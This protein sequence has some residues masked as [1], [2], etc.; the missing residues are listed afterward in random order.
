MSYPN[1]EEHYQ[2]RHTESMNHGELV[3]GRVGEMGIISVGQMGIGEV[4][5]GDTWY[6]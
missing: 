3:K 4:G 1:V 6:P 5:T 2:H